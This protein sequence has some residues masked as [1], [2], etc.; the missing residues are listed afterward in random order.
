MSKIDMDR[1]LGCKS[2]C[3][4]KQSILLLQ[5]QEQQAQN[6][7]DIID[8]NEFVMTID[9]AL[10]G[11]T[12]VAPVFLPDIQ[13]QVTVGNS[14][15]DTIANLQTAL[16]K[17]KQEND[18]LREAICI[19]EIKVDAMSK[20]F[21]PD[22]LHRILNSKSKSHWSDESLE[23]FIKL[24]IKIGTK[25]YQYLR[26]KLNWPLPDPT[27]IQRHMNK[28]SFKPGESDDIV[29][30][31]NLKTCDFSEQ[32]KQ[33]GLVIDEMSTQSKLEWDP[34][35]G[36]FVGY[37]T[38]PTGP[39]LVEKRKKEGINQE[40]ILASHV[41][42][43]MIVGILIKFKQLLAY[44]HTDRSWCAKFIARWIVGLIRQLYAENGMKCMFLT[45]DQGKQ[46]LAL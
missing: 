11:D 1:R 27:T 23:V 31:V 41:F 4:N 26:N 30:L 22:Q 16:E 38:V 36:E 13:H 43:I 37:P 25:G 32:D 34:T 3:K 19:L 9:R 21:Q 46:N 29:K 5:D 12:F 28:I 14:Y 45:M 7:A 40:D 42:N 10:E 33:Y 18:K 15:Q 8:E 6:I 20:L 35:N 44:H 24:Y 2:D 17:Q 39:A